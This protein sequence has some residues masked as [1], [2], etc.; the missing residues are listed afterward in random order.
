MVSNAVELTYEQHA[1]QARA[2]ARAIGL[3]DCI[4]YAPNWSKRADA[5]Y[6]IANE[7]GL[8][9]WENKG[10]NPYLLP[11]GR[12]V[13]VSDHAWFFELARAPR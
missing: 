7:S 12:M 3:H 11:D 9:W 2:S 8:A 10:G 1:A 13:V 4:H 5:L 6:A